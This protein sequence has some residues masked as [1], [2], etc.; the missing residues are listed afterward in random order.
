MAAERIC[1]DDL[2]APRAN[3]AI[4]AAIAATPE[5]TLTT[6]A[7][8]EAARAATGLEDYGSPD[9]LPRLAIWLRSFDEDAGLNRVGRANGFADCVRQVATRLRF[10]ERWNAYPDIADVVIDRPI[11]IA[12]LPRSGTTNLV[13]L[14]A[15]D[16]RL[17]SMP[18]WET[19]E[20]VARHEPPPAPQDDPRRHDC[21][22]MWSQF[23]ALLPLMPAMHEM[24]PDAIHEDL[25]LLGPDFACYV[26]EW[27]CRAYRLRDF[28]GAHD[29]TPHYRYGKRLLQ[30]MTWSRGPNRW[31]LKSPSHMENLA[32][33]HT[34][35]PDACVVL[36]HRD[37]LAV[38]QSAITMIA[39]GDRL[40]RQR[41]DLP[42]LADYW[43]SRVEQMLHRCVAERDLL[44]QAIDVRFQDCMADQMGT[45]ARIYEVAGLELTDAA[46]AGISAYEQA[47]PRGKH[48]QVHYD[49]AGD[50]GVDVPALRRRF[51]FYTDRFDI[52]P[53]VGT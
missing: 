38:I 27:V 15:A 10:E 26:P 42:E 8:I 6:R 20:P 23:E 9:F 25:E 1:I 49:L 4:K 35:Y 51:R 16:A 13:N 7:V 24:D 39:Y 52:K 31:V 17:R 45:I 33:L 28:L 14:L 29:Q 3:P 2:A 18:L 36:T 19:M 44:P 46:R 12:G 50:F 43:I 37:P 47:N 21:Q 5:V 22:A 34:V 41:I 48:G 30:Y 32:A 11:V 53:E 40:R